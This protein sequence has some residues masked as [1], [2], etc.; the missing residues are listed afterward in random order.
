[1]S[2]RSMNQKCE[3]KEYEVIKILIEVKSSPQISSKA[4]VF[5]PADLRF[6]DLQ[7]QCLHKRKQKLLGSWGIHIFSSLLQYHVLFCMNHL[8]LEQSLV[9]AGFLCSHTVKGAS[10]LFP[11]VPT[12]AAANDVPFPLVEGVM[13]ARLQLLHICPSWVVLEDSYL[14]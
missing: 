13:A 2:L 5:L 4:Y 11:L 10:M 8:P 9:E 6:F 3:Q 12:E 14:W 1:M 7:E